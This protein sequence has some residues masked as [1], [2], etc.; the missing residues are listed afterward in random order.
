MCSGTSSCGRATSPRGNS[1]KSAECSAMA[2][3]PTPMSRRTGRLRTADV[4]TLAIVWF[5]RDLRLHDHP[6]L[7]TALR[8]HDRVVPLFVLDDALLGGRYAS[9]SRT[10]FMLGCLH[11]LDDELRERGSRL[12]IRHGR[13]EDEVPALARDLGAAA[14]L[15]TSD[16][17]PY[18]RRRDARVTRAL[19][20]AGVAAQPHGGGYLRDP[21][22]PRTRDGRPFTVFSPFHRHLRGMDARP[23]HRA[24][25]AL[26]PLPAELAAGRLPDAP[27]QDVVPEPVVAP[28]EPAARLALDAWLRGPL[29]HYADRHD[30]M[31]RIG[32]S[33]LSPYLR[34]GCLS[35]RECEERATRKGGPGASAWVRQ[36]A[37][38]DF[39][40][41]VLLAHPSLVDHEL[42]ER[43]RGTLR[44]AASD[45]HLEAWRT[46]R[47]G[48]PLVDAGMRELARTGWMHNR[49]RLVVGS[50]LTKALHADWREGERH[51]ARLLLDGEP[52]QNNGNWQWIAST[53]VDP[54]PYFRRLLNPTLQARKFDPEG[55]YIRHNVPEL[56]RVPGERIHEPWTMTGAEQE[57]AGCVIGRDY[58]R[59][60]VDHAQERR[61]ALALSRA[62]SG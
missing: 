18:A 48:F 50:F 55:R 60:I 29:G 56:A 12:V 52:A 20:A 34:W 10:A 9:P 25:G 44:W 26:P 21:S 41:H 53:G 1:G 49:A 28:G 11:A 36:L 62:A 23:V 38:R 42:Q 61:G 33:V 8:E 30:G 15:W 37:W 24:P 58:P 45:E 59:P 19:Q 57:A 17:S 54:A 4:P 6:A 7:V 3:D 27:A 14:V 5:R 13:P 32:T 35:A 16:V 39:Y 2:S 51:F 47:T 40:A 46:G 31:S 43:Y 22:R